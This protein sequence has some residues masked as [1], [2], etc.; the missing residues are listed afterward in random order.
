VLQTGR[1]A[2]A[3][4]SDELLASDEVRRAYLGL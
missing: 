2:L 1:V 4:S 3:G